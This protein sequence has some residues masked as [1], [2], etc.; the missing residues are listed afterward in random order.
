MIRTDE[1]RQHLERVA[2]TQLIDA[3]VPAGFIGHAYFYRHPAVSADLILLL[4]DR[5][6]PG[7]PGRPLRKRGTHFWQLTPDYPNVSGAKPLS[8][9]HIGDTQGDG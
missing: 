5:L 9:G 4:R 8:D 1:E 2:R 7:S 3:Q 6:E